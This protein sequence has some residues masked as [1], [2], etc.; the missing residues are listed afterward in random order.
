MN[1]QIEQLLTRIG[2]Q[3]VDYLPSL[4][5]GLL[6]IAIGLLLGWLTKRIVMKISIVM[7]IDRM[8]RRFRWAAGFSKADIRYAFYSSVGNMA[9]LV[10]FLILLTTALDALH[11]AFLSSM[12]RQGVLLVPRLL[13]AI[14]IVGI[15]FL[16]AGWIA[17]SVQSALGKEEIPRAGL[18]ARLVRAVVMLFAI[19]MGLLEFGIAKEI[20]LIGFTAIILTFTVSVVALVIV[21]AKELLA[22]LN[23]KDTEG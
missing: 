5:G 15:G 9:F 23:N 10:V 3:F 18:I 2:G 16:V 17:A 1:N 6:L 19:A 14:A 7:R 21:G 4:I 20:V 11:L 22:G 12:I 8:F 13:I